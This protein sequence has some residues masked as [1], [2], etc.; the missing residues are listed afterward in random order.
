MLYA[1]KNAILSTICLPPFLYVLSKPFHAPAFVADFSAS[2]TQISSTYA[3]RMPQ[4]YGHTDKK[5]FSQNQ[6]QKDSERT[7]FLTNL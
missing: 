5:I 7:F 3:P 6:A 1:F 4:K 2:R